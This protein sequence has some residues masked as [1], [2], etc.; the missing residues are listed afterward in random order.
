MSDKIFDRIKELMGQYPSARANE[1][2]QH[3]NFE[4]LDLGTQDKTEGE[5]RNQ[6]NPGRLRKMS[7]R[8]LLTDAF[9]TLAYILIINQLG[10]NFILLLIGFFIA[11]FLIIFSW[12]AQIQSYDNMIKQPVI[13][14]SDQKMLYFIFNVPVYIALFYLAVKGWNLQ[15]M[16]SFFGGSQLGMWLSYF[17][18]IYWEKKNHKMIY[19][20][21]NCG[22]WKK[23]Y[24]IKE[25]N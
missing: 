6:K 3:T 21:K 2:R 15:A 17:Q 18:L 25:R 24:I 5:D 22:I 9:F 7:N 8:I 1:V 13:D 11:L 20:G 14:R 4:G 19:F 12:K 16:V 23:S 10:V